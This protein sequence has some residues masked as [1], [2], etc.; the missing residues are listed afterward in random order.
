MKQ[1]NC[2]KY[3]GV[4]LDGKLAWKKHIEQIQTKLLAASGAIYKL[5]KY[6]PQR[7]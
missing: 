1:D 3:L 4:I 7:A 6:I 5:H 2:I